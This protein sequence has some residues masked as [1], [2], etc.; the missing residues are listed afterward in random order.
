MNY[1][2]ASKFIANC[3]R[4]WCSIPRGPYLAKRVISCVFCLFDFPHELSTTSRLC[5]L[6]LACSAKPFILFTIYPTSI[7]TLLSFWISPYF[8][9]WKCNSGNSYPHLGV[10]QANVA[11]AVGLL[12]GINFCQ[13]TVSRF[14]T[15]NLSLSNM[16]K[17]RPLLEEWLIYA[18]TMTANGCSTRDLPRVLSRSAF[19]QVNFP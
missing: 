7:F 17:L 18:E 13:T 3:S 10:T 14:E 2:P 15:M 11:S 19:K 9:S 12:N 8:H 5:A 16:R 4:D 1:F 6:Q